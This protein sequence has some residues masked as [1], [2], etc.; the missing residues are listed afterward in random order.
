[1]V[2]I[3]PARDPLAWVRGGFL[4]LAGTAT[5]MSVLVALNLTQDRW[6]L[7]RLRE[8][9]TIGWIAAILFVVV[10]RQPAERIAALVARGECVLGHRRFFPVASGT[11]LAFL[12]LVSLTRH[13]SFQ[14]FSHDFSVFDLA[15]APTGGGWLD[16]PILGGSFLAEHFSP[17][18]LALVPLRA[19]VA[20]PYLLV[21]LYP[22]VIWAAV[23]PLW[24]LL[25]GAGATLGSA[26]LIC[27]LFLNAPILV[28]SVEYG[29]H[30]E[31]LLPLGVLT[32]FLAHR[33]GCRAV[34]WL[35]VVGC[36]SIKEDVAFYLVGFAA[37]LALGERRWL[38]AAGVVFVSTAW[39]VLAVGV[40]MPAFGAPSD[41]RFLSRWDAWGDGL[42]GIVVGVGTQP[43]QLAATLSDRA[44]VELFV[45]LL[46]LPLASRWA[47]TLVLSP[48]LLNT[49]SGLPLQAGLGGYYGLPALGFA[50]MAAVVGVES[51]RFSTLAARPWRVWLVIA[52]LVLSV[53]T[54]CLVPHLG[55]RPLQVLRPLDEIV[56]DRVLLRFDDATWPFEP[57]EA[58]ALAERLVASGEY[59]A[60]WVAPGFVFLARADTA[61]ARE[62]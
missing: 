57:V 31:G 9:A 16:S 7:D 50:A 21:V 40:W 15:L 35:L 60:E 20:T 12:L 41:Y 34:F 2:P 51:P 11:M 8:P 45:G 17:V 25:R 56:A 18:L 38:R 30:V 27:L 26:N 23:F 6:G 58:A 3:A 22:V 33:S 52:A 43:L 5:A 48:L 55:E 54:A 59:L 36:L 39:L 32:L 1:M 10:H 49:T 46:F 4:A 53:S 13:W 28:T 61:T 37:Y 14:T 24:R 29:F 42:G 44:V 19:V 62:D 47:W